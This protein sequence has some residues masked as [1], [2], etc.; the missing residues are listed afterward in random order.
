MALRLAL[1]LVCLTHVVLKADGVDAQDLVCALPENASWVDN[2]ETLTGACRASCSFGAAEEEEEDEVASREENVALA[3]GL[4]TAAGLSTSV[5]AAFVFFD[6]FVTQSN[7]KILAISLGFSGGVMMYVSFAEIL[8]KSVAEFEACDCLWEHED[9]SAPAKIMATLMFF[10]GILFFVLLDILVHYIMPHIVVRRRKK[11]ATN[12]TKNATTERA[13]TSVTETPSEFRG[14]PRQQASTALPPQDEL[15]LGDKANSTPAPGAVSTLAGTTQERVEDEEETELIQIRACLCDDHDDDSEHVIDLDSE[16]KANVDREL[17]HMGMMTALAIGLHNFPEGLATFVGTLADPSVGVGL[18]TA[19]A[20]HN[21]P[22]GLCVSIPIYYATGSRWRGFILAS[23][24]GVSEI[25]GAAL[26]YAFLM[27][28]FDST[29]Y[30]VL[31]GLVAGMMVAIVVSELLPTAQR[32]D[33]KGHIVTMSFFVG[34]AVM[35]LSLIL[36]QL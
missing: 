13:S 18:A 34:M 9:P 23:V 15:A 2:N 26:G 28:V 31:F 3:F 32:Y 17:N 12:G 36:F 1:G 7:G 21:I 27:A 8:L 24:S 6:R 14:E 11:K 10:A 5:G 29:A 30:A 16:N 33:P 19:I 25:I 20:I 35:A 4:V 22:E